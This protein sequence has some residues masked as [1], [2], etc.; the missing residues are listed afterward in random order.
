MSEKTDQKKIALR[1]EYSYFA[2]P[3]ELF[4][5]LISKNKN[6]EALPDEFKIE[7]FLVKGCVSNLWLIPSYDETAGV[8][9]FKSDADSV[10]TRGIAG[11]VCETYDGLS[12]R[13]IPEIPPSFFDEIGIGAQLSP[14]RRNGL[15][16]LCEKIESFAKFHLSQA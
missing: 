14:N 15:G 5:Y 11:L 1:E 13:E 12:P 9:R 7:E 16:K 8:C 2:D 6:K 10:I 4:E 3:Q